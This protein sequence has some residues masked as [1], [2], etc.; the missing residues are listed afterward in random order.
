MM[1]N[2]TSL[3]RVKWNTSSPGIIFYSLAPIGGKGRA[4]ST[5]ALLGADS[6]SS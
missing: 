4:E 2:E 1:R 5:Q 3:M 6:A